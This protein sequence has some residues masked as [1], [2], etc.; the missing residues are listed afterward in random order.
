MHS[1]MGIFLPGRK[2]D[3]EQDSQFA[4]GILDK[5]NQAASRGS[6]FKSQCYNLLAC[7]LKKENVTGRTAEI[8]QADGICRDFFVVYGE[9]FHVSDIPKLRNLTNTF[10]LIKS[11]GWCD[12]AGMRDTLEQLNKLIQQLVKNKA[13]QEKIKDFFQT[14]PAVICTLIADYDVQ[15][16]ADLFKIAAEVNHIP[17]DRCTELGKHC[18]YYENVQQEHLYGFLHHADESHLLAFFK[19][20]SD[21]WER[22]VEKEGKDPHETSSKE[23]LLPCITMLKMLPKELES[24]NLTGCKIWREAFSNIISGDFAANIFSDN[25]CNLKVLNLQNSCVKELDCELFQYRNLKKLEEL[26][27]SKNPTLGDQLN[28]GTLKCFKPLNLKLLD[29]RG[30]TTHL[31]SKF[32]QQLKTYLPG[33]TILAEPNIPSCEEKE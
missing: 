14:F 10:S 25:F 8:K 6:N 3:E 32:L 28:A 24:L 9:L 12:R 2:F 5:W 1:Q 21:E 27:V 15:H 18:V 31:S 7:V 16:L 30:S 26:D 29:L 20:Y 11:K 19:G 13:G 4:H 33:V 22:K 23:A 17:L